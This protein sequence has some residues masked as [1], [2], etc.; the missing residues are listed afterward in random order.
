MQTFQK[1]A[2]LAKQAWLSDEQL[3]ARHALPVA[4]PAVP[5]PYLG[6]PGYQQIQQQRVTRYA[7]PVDQMDKLRAFPVMAPAAQEYEAGALQRGSI[8]PMKAK[9]LEYGPADTAKETGLQ[10]AMRVAAKYTPGATSNPGVLNR[11]IP[12]VATP[13]S[14]GLG[15]YSGN[16]LSSGGELRINPTAPQHKKSPY[17]FLDT[18]S[19]ETTHASDTM[20][21]VLTPGKWLKNMVSP[22]IPNAAEAGA[23]AY[24]R[25]HDNAQ[26]EQMAGP[27]HAMKAYMVNKTRAVPE[28]PGGAN[29]Q[30]RQFYQEHPNPETTFPIKYPA[31]AWRAIRKS[32]EAARIYLQ[33]VKTAPPSSAPIPGAAPAPVAPPVVKMAMALPRLVKTA[34]L[35]AHRITD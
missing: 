2:Q 34:A 26:H 24:W 31:E 20:R 28:N 19:H 11:D 13:G 8:N 22:T 7:P 10:K 23:N 18:V 12:V 3:N 6:S 9:Q 14:S 15:Q 21:G 27:F 25:A 33:T 1:A 4:K 29:G 17:D 16:I 32:P 5:A 30:I 35:W